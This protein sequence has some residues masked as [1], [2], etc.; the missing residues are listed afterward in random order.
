M[1]NQT[2]ISKK[3]KKMLQ[4]INN[5]LQFEEFIYEWI[6]LFKVFY[7]SKTLFVFI[8]FRALFQKVMKSENLKLFLRPKLFIKSETI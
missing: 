8:M 1:S 2:C 4:S 7:T 6:L 3:G 5:M